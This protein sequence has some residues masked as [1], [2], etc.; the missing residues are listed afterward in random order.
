MAGFTPKV[1]GVQSRVLGELERE[2]ALASLAPAN[3]LKPIDASVGVV[4][5]L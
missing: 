2:L 4:A 1:L 5:K 3:V